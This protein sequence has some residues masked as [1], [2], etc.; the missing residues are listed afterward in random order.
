[1]PALPVALVPRHTNRP[2]FKDKLRI[3]KYGYMHAPVKPGLGYEFDRG[4]LDNM[5]LR[6]E[7]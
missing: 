2:Y 5:M 6:V 4:V 1:M 3:D 7:N